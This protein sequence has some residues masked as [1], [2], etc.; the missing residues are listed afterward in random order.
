VGYKKEMKIHYYIILILL[1]TTLSC[2]KAKNQ[3]L[4][5]EWLFIYYMP[6]DNNLSNLGDDIIE[7]IRKGTSENV[8][9][10]VLSDFKEKNGIFKYQIVNKKIKTTRNTE[11]EDS[12][13]IQ[14]FDDYLSWVKNTINFENYVIVILN[15]GGKLDEIG[16]DE[17][18]KESYLKIDKIANSIKFFSQ[19]LQKI[20]ELLF[21]QVCA[22]GALST[23]LEFQKCSKY[24]MYSQTILGA[25]NYYYEGVLK[26]V[27]ED[28]N[29]T[30][31]EI[32]ELIA[33]EDALSMFNSYTCI[34]NHHIGDLAQKYTEFI[35]IVSKSSFK[36]DESKI[37]SYEYSGEYY[38]DMISFVNSINSTDSTQFITQKENIKKTLNKTISFNIKNPSKEF[39]NDYSGISIYSPYNFEIKKYSN[40]KLFKNQSYNLF[41]NRIGTRKKLNS[42]QETDVKSR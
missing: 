15:H 22:K 36:I 34:N 16:L 32:G 12:G 42:I 11:R 23:S 28:K 29:L 38:W 17:Y 26:K 9:A 31:Q 1:S 3:R 4:S 8:G 7:M 18:P 39:V 30:G 35:D 5:V 6:Y 41:V 27:G 10:T 13:D 25:P 24:T 14:C 2:Q 19:S 37:I 33:K 20:P 21:L 40:L